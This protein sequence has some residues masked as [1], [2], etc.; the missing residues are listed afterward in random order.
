MP[1][2]VDVFAVIRIDAS[3]FVL[4]FSLMFSCCIVVLYYMFRYLLGCCAVLCAGVLLFLLLRL[5]CCFSCHCWSC[6][7]VLCCSGG[8]LCWCGVMKRR[9]CP[10]LLQLK[11]AIRHPPVK[12]R[13]NSP[14]RKQR[15]QRKQQQ[16]KVCWA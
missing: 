14:G 9:N 16:Q 2:L 8:V 13:S 11:T 10:S 7:V 4:L 12:K 1:G 15:L 3:V 5:L 6:G